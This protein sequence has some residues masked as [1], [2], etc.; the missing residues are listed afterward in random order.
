[1]RVAWRAGLIAIAAIGCG[2]SSAKSDGGALAGG[3]GGGSTGAAGSGT[4][5]A[6]GSGSNGSCGNV[7]PCGGSLVGTWSFT[8]ECINS[9]VFAPQTQAICAQA[10]VSSVN[11]SVSGSATFDASMVY[12]VTQNV[13]AAVVWNVPASCVAGG[14]CAD[15]ADT[16]QSQLAAGVTF[17]CTG[18]SDCSCTESVVGSTTDNGTY[19]TTGSVLAINSAVSGSTTTGGYCIQ[20]STLHLLTVDAT[21]N[22][23][24]MGQATIDKDV[25]A[26]KQ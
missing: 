20:G 3:S 16:F 5:G 19:S 14:T 1:M 15:F 11:A 18:S 21:M 6:A 4:G 2:G 7:E 17:T 22:M 13:T 8:A 24:P 25:V 26:Q 23:G 9:M 10:S 12:S